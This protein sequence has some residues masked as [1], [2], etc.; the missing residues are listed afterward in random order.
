MAQ[1]DVQR[2]RLSPAERD[3]VL[4]DLTEI[5]ART[6]RVR[7]H[8]LVAARRAGT[9][10]SGW[11]TRQLD[12]LTAAAFQLTKAAERAPVVDV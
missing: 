9:S 11:S 4:L 6:D 1:E 3:R 8:L 7:D 12:A 10:P 5:L 2:P